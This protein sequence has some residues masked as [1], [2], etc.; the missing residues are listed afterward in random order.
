M[1][2]FTVANEQF[3]RELDLDIDQLLGMNKAS[4]SDYLE[5]K[6]FISTHLEEIAKYL[7]ILGDHQTDNATKTNAFGT[8]INL[9]EIANER[10]DI[11]NMGR[12]GKLQTLEKKLGDAKSK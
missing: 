6:P 2:G 5:A 3:K 10:S 4:L 11:Y 7:E 8:A 9:L 1:E 12:Q